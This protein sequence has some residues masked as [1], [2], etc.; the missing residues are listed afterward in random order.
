MTRSKT[1][2]SW[3]I[4]RRGRVRCS[5]RG[6]RQERT[7]LLHRLH[8]WLLLG[9]RRPTWL[10]ARQTQTPQLQR[11]TPTRR[12]LSLYRTSTVP[13]A[14]CIYWVIYG[15]TSHVQ[16]AAQP[17]TSAQTPLNLE[18]WLWESPPSDGTLQLFSAQRLEAQPWNC[19]I[20]HD[21]HRY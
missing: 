18:K 16:H 11:R 19:W 17:A 13:I 9:R 20:L 15:H 3:R 12:T 8:S 14:S 4:K 2:M 5:A 10:T 6:I 1:A 7:A 21:F